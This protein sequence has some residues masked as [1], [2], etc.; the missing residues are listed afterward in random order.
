MNIWRI[1][2]KPEIGGIN[3]DSRNK[4]IQIYSIKIIDSLS[5]W[6]GMSATELLRTTKDCAVRSAMI[7]NAWNRH[8]T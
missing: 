8:D 3:K 7:T 4:L 1:Y 6:C 5:T 2:I